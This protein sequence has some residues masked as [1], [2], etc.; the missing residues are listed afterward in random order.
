L[1]LTKES[2]TAS[3]PAGQPDP[4]NEGVMLDDDNYYREDDD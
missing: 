3:N 1:K 4:V 2:P